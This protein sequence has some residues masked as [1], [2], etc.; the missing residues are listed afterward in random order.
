MRPWSGC[1]V[2]TRIASAVARFMLGSLAAIAV[3]VVGGFFAL[4]SITI[5]EA[6]RD[7]RER[8]R[9]EGRLVET[10]ASP[11]AS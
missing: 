3:I 4:R 5:H 8:V 6:E 1:T 2:A 11:T 10:A 9:L 7:T